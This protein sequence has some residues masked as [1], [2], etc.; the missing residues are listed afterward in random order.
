MSY[1]LMLDNLSSALFA[2]VR[3]AFTSCFNPNSTRIDTKKRNTLYMIIMKECQFIKL[4]T[5][6]N[7]D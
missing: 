1:R 6:R 2:F 4:Q 5:Y 7:K 3:Y